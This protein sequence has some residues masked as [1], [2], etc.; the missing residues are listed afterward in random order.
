MS[1]RLKTTAR[2]GSSRG[3]GGWRPIRIPQ[4]SQRVAP[5]PKVRHPNGG[6]QPDYGEDKH[7]FEGL[8]GSRRRQTSKAAIPLAASPQC[9]LTT[10]ERIATADA[11]DANAT[12]DC[13]T[14]LR[15]N[16]RFLP[17]KN[18]KNICIFTHAG[19]KMLLRNDE[20][21][22]KKKEKRTK[23]HVSKAT[24]LRLLAAK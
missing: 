22:E 13:R 4:L 17:D 21:K 11:A 15:D 16:R 5:T 12:R 9:N 7:A 20:K 1:Q 24:L 23:P 14:T 8:I 18:K 2:A 6:W 3:N 19:I 10:L